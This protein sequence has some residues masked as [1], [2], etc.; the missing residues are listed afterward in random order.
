MVKNLP[1]MQETQVQFLDHTFSVVRSIFGGHRLLPPRV[2]E[3]LLSLATLSCVF[4]T[5]HTSE[6]TA[7]LDHLRVQCFRRDCQGEMPDRK[8][9]G[10][11]S[12]HGRPLNTSIRKQD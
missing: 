6:P 9:G 11:L 7:E 8:H 10:R 4:S 1:A 3:K 2:L 5:S 12:G